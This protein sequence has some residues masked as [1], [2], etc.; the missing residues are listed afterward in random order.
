MAES[1]K[2]REERLEKLLEAVNDASRNVRAAFLTFLVAG[3][4]FAIL[5][6]STTDEQL[7]KESGI[8]LPLLSVE[9]PIVGFYI[10]A[11]WLFWLLHLNLLLLLRLLAGKID[12]LPMRL[13]ETFRHRLHTFPFTQLRAGPRQAGAARF[14]LWAMAWISIVALPVI[15]LMWAQARFLAYHGDWITFFHQLAVLADLAL[16]WLLWPRAAASKGLVKALGYAVSIVLSLLLA[17]FS[18]FDAVVPEGPWENN[19]GRL[20]PG[21]LLE[22]VFGGRVRYLD[23]AEK[24]LVLEEAPPEILAAYIASK[25]DGEMKAARLGHTRGL[26]L[27]DRD[28]RNADLSVARLDKADLRE[29][30]LQGANLGLA[31]LQGADL[32]GA[33]LQGANLSGAELQGAAL[34]DAELQGAVLSG[35]KLQGA[36]L[37]NAKLQGAD[38][39]GASLGGAR[40]FNVDLRA[41]NLRDVN[42]NKLTTD[43]WKKLKDE[44]AAAVPAGVKRKRALKRIGT[45]MKT[46]TTI[47]PLRAEGAIYDPRVPELADL[48]KQW[49]PLDRGAYRLSEL[50]LGILTGIACDGGYAAAGIARRAIE[51]ALF[52]DPHLAGALLEQECQAIRA[53]PEDLKAKLREAAEGA[54]KP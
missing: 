12:R 19:V 18:L 50:R 15:V 4:Y 43:E 3:L 8:V 27:H 23:L 21:N 16:L 40:L 33:K 17:A 51:I 9:L 1:T 46:E 13:P 52:D 31:K 38:L 30:R 32:R 47:V 10:I 25:R 22:K 39:S 49:P 24:T 41:A 37:F 26:D 45:A 20:Y 28:L 34:F 5:I 6:G 14:L 35:A 11:P 36:D 48:P 44:I 42:F 53:L 7:L 29:A 2:E 54:D